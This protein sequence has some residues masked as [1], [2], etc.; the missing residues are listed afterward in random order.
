MK[1]VFVL[2]SETRKNLVGEKHDTIAKKLSAVAEGGPRADTETESLVKTVSGAV[3]AGD[4][5]PE[6]S[7]Q[8]K[9]KKK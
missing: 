8:K 7:S 3:S 5:I 1:N 4:D 9:N 2:D 6:K